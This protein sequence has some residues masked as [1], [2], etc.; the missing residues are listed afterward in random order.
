MPRIDVQPA[1]AGPQ[2]LT[3]DLADGPRGHGGRAMISTYFRSHSL[4]VAGSILSLLCGAGNA[5]AQTSDLSPSGL[6]RLNLEIVEAATSA[7]AQGLRAASD[8][9]RALVERYL[10]GLAALAGRSPEDAEFRRGV[11]ARFDRQDPRATRY[12]QLLGRRSVGLSHDRHGKRRSEECG[13][14]GA[15]AH[16]S[17]VI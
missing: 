12:W 5:L 7:R 11:R 16:S 17:I 2:A 14:E 9:S 10:A 4:T 6:E 3:Y 1:I 15:C 13:E 8:A